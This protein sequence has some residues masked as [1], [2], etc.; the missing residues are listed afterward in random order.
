MNLKLRRDHLPLFAPYV[1]IIGAFGPYLGATGVRLEQIV[2]YLCA[3]VLLIFKRQKF[4]LSKS[5]AV[6]VAAWAVILLIGIVNTYFAIADHQL[7]IPAA[8]TMQIEGAEQVS[9]KSLFG[10]MDNMLVPM[11]SCLV[12]VLALHGLS[13]EERRTATLRLCAMVTGALAVNTML[14][15]LLVL[16]PDRGFPIVQ[17]FW[18][19]GSSV[20]FA[21]FSQQR[22]C[23]V[24]NQP[25]EAGTA[26][27]LGLLLWSYRLRHRAGFSTLEAFVVVLLIAGGVLCASKIFFFVG[28]P[29]ALIYVARSYKKAESAPIRRH[30]MKVGGVFAGLVVLAV[31]GAAALAPSSMF[32][33]QQVQSFLSDVQNL[34]IF[35]SLTGGR[36]G[37]SSPEDSVVTY[38]ATVIVGRSPVFGLGFGSLAAFDSAYIQILAFSGLVG[39]GLYL[40]AIGTMIGH[41]LKHRSHGFWEC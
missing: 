2:I 7:I 6:I 3:I 40:T 26:Y 18:P 11:A 20:G 28:V 10:G 14:S 13:T 19:P 27:S 5:S 4:T 38:Y 36:F 8:T 12:A 15:G 17:L 16:A 25:G 1:C 23:G 37:G 22:V 35:E 30:A 29:L 32:Q 33:F 34:S 21:S 39:L 41:F 9:W 24:F 31:V